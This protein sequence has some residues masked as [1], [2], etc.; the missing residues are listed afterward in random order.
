MFY[1]GSKNFNKNRKIKNK[2]YRKKKRKKYNYRNNKN[3]NNYF[4]IKI[5]QLIKILNQIQFKLKY[6]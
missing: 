1:Y 4:L 2:K 6:Q 5:S 3:K